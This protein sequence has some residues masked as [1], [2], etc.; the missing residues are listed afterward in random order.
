MAIMS[1]GLICGGIWYLVAALSG[2]REQEEVLYSQAVERWSRARQDFAHLSI[3]ASTRYQSV[4][5]H[6]DSTPD[7]L[8]DTQSAVP[9]PGY[10]A[11]TYRVTKVP[12][13]FLPEAD[14]DNTQPRKVPVNRHDMAPTPSLFPK[15][16]WGPV[17]SVMLT[18]QDQAGM[19]DPLLLST[20]DFPV[21]RVLIKHAPTPAP[22]IKCRREL[23][24]VL[25]EGMCWV[26]WQLAGICVQV[27]RP[28]AFD[29]DLD[30]ASWRLAPR[31]QELNE[32]YGC[33]YSEGR[34]VV[35]RYEKVPPAQTKGL[36][37]F[38]NLTVEVRSA[39][40]PYLR[41]L[42]LTGGTLDFGTPSADNR[43]M[44]LVMLCLGAVV[45]CPPCCTL[46]GARRSW[47]NFLT[48]GDEEEQEARDFSTY[49]SF[50][51]D[52]MEMM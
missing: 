31:L 42:E 35:P 16:R 29:Q 40:D 33:D 5:L 1:L 51:F 21:T 24:G 34:W 17:V 8:H 52:D 22:E 7:A 9:L 18:I 4:D 3:A 44:G 11:L 20:G 2:A 49:S 38:D 39:D 43:I 50:E 15:Q 13:G 10:T 48:S 27:Q 23:G 14:F 25:K 47:T 28:R 46:C 41:A 45:A 12:Q 36:A 30:G 19:E 26:H 6:A 32:S 37:R